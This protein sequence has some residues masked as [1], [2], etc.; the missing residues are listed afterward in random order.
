[1]RRRL[2]VFNVYSEAKA[3]EKLNYM[4]NNPVRAGLVNEPAD[5]LYGSAGGPG[6]GFLLPGCVAQKGEVWYFLP[7]PV[8]IEIDAAM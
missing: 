6:N 4:H 3:T 8:G 1:M 5:W 2:R 7:K